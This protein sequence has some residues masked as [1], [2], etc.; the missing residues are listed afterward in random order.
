MAGKHWMVRQRPRC[1]RIYIIQGARKQCV[2]SDRWKLKLRRRVSGRNCQHIWAHKLFQSA[3]VCWILLRLYGKILMLCN[4]KWTLWTSVIKMYLLS[5]ANNTISIYS[6]VFAE[7]WSL[8]TVATTTW[9]RCRL[10]NKTE[11]IPGGAFNTMPA[12]TQ[13]Y[14][15]SKTFVA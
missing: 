11:A 10:K 7:I 3:C 8:V 12:Q 5:Y 9:K 14:A 6:Y 1:E 2:L 15:H 4:W 13:H